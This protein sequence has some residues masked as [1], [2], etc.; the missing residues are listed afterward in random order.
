MNLLK[1]QENSLY[2]MYHFSGCGG[3]SIAD[4]GTI[5]S[6][7][8][9]SPYPSNSNCTYQI[10]VLGKRQIHL[11]FQSFNLFKVNAGS[12]CVD[13]GD[14]IEVIFDFREYFTNV[15]SLYIHEYCLLF[16]EG[17]GCDSNTIANVQTFC[18]LGKLSRLNT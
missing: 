3:Y 6:P 10:Q 15:S 17:K 4:S 12:S 16:N 2:M 14:Y 8:Y 13:D 18:K 11:V 7:S 1:L 9:P 5:S